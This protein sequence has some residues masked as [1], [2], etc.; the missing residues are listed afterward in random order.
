M[1]NDPDND[2]TFTEKE[3]N[4]W[5]KLEDQRIEIAAKEQE[6]KKSK[7]KKKSDA[8]LVRQGKE[9][10]DV[11]SKAMIGRE[12]TRLGGRS[13]KFDGDKVVAEKEDGS[14][15][16]ISWDELNPKKEKGNS[17]G[18]AGNVA[19][20]LQAMAEARAASEE[21]KL[22]LMTKQMEMKD[23]ADQ[24]MME[25]KEKADQRRHQEEMKQR[26]LEMK[27][28]EQQFQLQIQ[29]FEMQRLTLLAQ[30][31]QANIPISPTMMIGN[32]VTVGST[33]PPA[34]NGM[35]GMDGESPQKKARNEADAAAWT[36]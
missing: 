12:V 23:K 20:A 6:E 33:L 17:G 10:R 8:E 35:N 27:Q 28:Q 32:G 14:E 36:D 21:Y 3:A 31:S 26:E 5:S 7:D 25:M 1:D 15:F 11:A 16:S 22:K 30:L 13:W 19:Q 24:R 18:R 2:P 34:S 4:L 29:Q 9:E